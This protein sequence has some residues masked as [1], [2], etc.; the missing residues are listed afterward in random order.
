MEFKTALHKAAALCSRQEQSSGDIRRKLER[1]NVNKDDVRKILEQLHQ[2]NFLDD[3][4]YARMFVRDKFRFNQWG[5]VKIRHLLQ[6][7]EISGEQAEHALS[8]VDPD[9][10]LETCFELADKKA[11]SLRVEDPF[12]RRNKLFRYLTGRGFEPDVIYK[13]LEK[14]GDV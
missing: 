12:I 9:E 2:E 1:W 13:A 3:G 7:K 8:A 5:K 6:Q 11:S 4:R 10:Y 14:M